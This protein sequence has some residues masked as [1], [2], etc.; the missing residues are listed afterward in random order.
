MRKVTK[1][2]IQDLNFLT[3]NP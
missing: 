3:L 2:V 1:R